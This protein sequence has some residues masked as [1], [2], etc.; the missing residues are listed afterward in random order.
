MEVGIMTKRVLVV[1]GSLRKGSYSTAI[2]RA[3]T[4]V[5]LADASFELYDGVRGLPHYDQDLD[6]ESPPA[7]VA[8]LRSDLAGAHGVLLITPEYNYNVPGGLKNFIDWASRPFAKHSLIG[9]RM[10]V[11]GCSPGERGG[12]AAV[13]YLRNMVPLFGGT[14]VGPELLFPK[15]NTLVSTDGAVAPEVLD[16]VLAVARELA[17]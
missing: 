3:V 10:A 7:S 16:P 5:S 11:V 15:I 8:T 2:A 12:K 13:E 9:R 6:T 17:Q 1:S 14:L 4:R